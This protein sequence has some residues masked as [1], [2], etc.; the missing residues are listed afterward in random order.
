MMQNCLRNFY[1]RPDEFSSVEQCQ[2]QSVDRQRLNS[3]GLKP[4]AWRNSLVVKVNWLLTTATA[5]QIYIQLVAINDISKV[6]SSPALLVKWIYVSDWDRNSLYTPFSRSLQFIL[7]DCSIAKVAS[8]T[9]S[10]HLQL[11][12]ADQRLSARV[13]GND[14][15]WLWR[16]VMV[17]KVVQVHRRLGM[18]VELTDCR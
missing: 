15:A 5:Q 4:L 16:G 11:N 3:A 9:I 17:Q 10:F 12:S 6:W 13:S 1:S 14:Y 8:R 18:S 7:Y 2:K